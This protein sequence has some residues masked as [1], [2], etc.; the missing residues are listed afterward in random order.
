MMNRQRAIAWFE[1]AIDVCKTFPIAND[2]RIEAYR[3]ALGALKEQH[4]VTNKYGYCPLCDKTI[5]VRSDKSMGH[6]YHCGHD[7]V[8]H[9]K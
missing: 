2:D 9:D 4:T 8:F 5:E 1:G 6:C 7:V 3:I